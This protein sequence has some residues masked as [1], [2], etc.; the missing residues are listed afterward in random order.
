MK[1]PGWSGGS[2]K[3]IAILSPYGAFIE[4]PPAT[5]GGCLLWRAWRAKTPDPLVRRGMPRDLSLFS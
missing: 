3:L 4:K 1:T 2:I 5:A